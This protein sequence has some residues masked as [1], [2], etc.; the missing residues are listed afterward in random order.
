MLI[1]NTISHDVFF[2]IS[3]SSPDM[4][5]NVFSNRSQ[6][7]RVFL[8]RSSVTLTNLSLDKQMKIYNQQQKFQ[9]TLELFDEASKQ[10]KQPLSS[11]VVVHA[12]KACART[13]DLQRGLTI[14]RLVTTRVKND[15]YILHSLLTLYSE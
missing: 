4:L 9:R 15:S 13:G 1:R 3:V 14:H 11:A 8:V 6:S 2:Q 12:L 7:V 5:T 10:P